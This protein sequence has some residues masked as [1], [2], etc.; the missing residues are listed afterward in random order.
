MVFEHGGSPK[1]HILTS[2]ICV[3]LKHLNKSV[4]REFHPSPH[5]EEILAQTTG[6][7]VFTK[8][9]SNWLLFGIKP[10]VPFKKG[11]VYFSL[12]AKV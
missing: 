6:A 1:L 5:V 10:F 2:K 11:A 12:C 4:Q 8:L 9:D 3:N 7:Q